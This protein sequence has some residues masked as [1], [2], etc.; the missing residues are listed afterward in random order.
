MSVQPLGEILVDVGR[1]SRLQLAEALQ[2]QKEERGRIGEVLV[3]LGYMTKRQI[4]LLI[5]EHKKRIPLGEYLVEAGVITPEDLDFALV[6]KSDSRDPLG[7]ILVRL[8]IIDEERLAKFLSQ[9][10]DMPYIEPYKRLVDLNL[11]TRLPRVFM[12]HNLILPISKNSG[13][14]T[15]VVAGLP[16]E[17][18]T[19]QLSAVFGDE[20]DLAISTPTKIRETIKALTDSRVAPEPDFTTDNKGKIEEKVSR[21]D[22][23][24]IGN[25][26][27][28]SDNRVAEWLNYII[29]E[30]IRERASD[31]HIE[32]MTDNVRVRFRVN[33]LL[34]HKID[35]PIGLR[36][37]VFRRIKALAGMKF[38]DTFRDQEGRLLGQTDKTNID[39]RVSTFVGIHGE[40]I[41]MRLFSHDDGLIELNAIGLTPNVYGMLRRALE[42]ATGFVILCG[43][44]GSGKTTTMFAAVHAI[45]QR[46]LKI[47][48]IEDPVEYHIPGVIQTQ[49]SS[50]RDSSLAE[51]IESA[52]H[53][54]PDVIA[55]GEITE[56]E[57]ARVALRAA[58]MGYKMLTTFHAND[59]LGA[60]LRLGNT[61]LETFMRSSTPF[62]IVCQRLV[63]KVCEDCRAVITP[64]PRLLSQF[65]IRD[66]DSTKYDFCHGVGCSN[67]NNT[68]Y[69]GR[70]GIFEAITVTEDLRQAYMR[71]APSRE[72]LKLARG[73][74]PFLTLAEI[75][76]LKAIRQ[77]TTVEEIIRVAPFS[78]HSRGDS[79]LL[80]FQEIEHISEST[81]YVE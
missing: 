24:E 50:H 54:D 58:L 45:N 71:G 77:I 15:V 60:L 3:T 76:C 69:R 41:N 12:Q 70:T 75:G 73:S 34:I 63:R 68:G 48:T 79:E 18:I 33:G 16:D 55:I 51:I 25:E 44:P 31:I 66:F 74:S 17:A 52:V 49:M 1:V 2:I 30:A 38:S 81:G 53:Q 19:L 8:Q 56:E 21:I 35:M 13:I 23:T 67:C 5:A 59:A 32:S 46:H 65:P 39:L 37:G 29:N 6:Q 14:V 26:K 43:P 27:G 4:R 47:V 36:A 64:E 72:F 40:T 61:H 10:L 20:I 7:Q 28:S 80:S 57:E 78:A 9:Q 62:T 22:L 42:H 11:F